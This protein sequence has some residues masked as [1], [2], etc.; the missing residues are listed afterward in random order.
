MMKT[1]YEANIFHPKDLREI[2][3]QFYPHLVQRFGKDQLLVDASISEAIINSWKHGHGGAS[4]ESIKLKVTFLD[5]MMIVRVQDC[6]EG[7]NWRDYQVASDM[8]HWFPDV[9]D[10]EGTGRGIILMLRV[11]DD[12][13]YNDKGNEC[14]LMKK[15]RR[16]E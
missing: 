9:E 15:Y 6:G 16:Q 7:F 14:L 11:M 12:L 10:L 13:R 8:K 5:S 1:S 4:E 3:K 2:R